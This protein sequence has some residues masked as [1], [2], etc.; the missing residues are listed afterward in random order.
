[1]LTK[2]VIVLLLI[3]IWTLVEILLTLLTGMSNQT[4]TPGNSSV[5]QSCYPSRIRIPPDHCG[6]YVCY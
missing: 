2:F 6:T 3:L 1:M 4:D 5:P